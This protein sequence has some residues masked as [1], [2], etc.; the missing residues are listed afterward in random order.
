MLIFA[1]ILGAMADPN[2]W[3][4]S[5]INPD[6][7]LNIIKYTLYMRYF[8]NSGANATRELPLLV[9]DRNYLGDKKLRNFLPHIFRDGK[10]DLTLLNPVYFDNLREMI[11]IANRHNMTF[12]FSIF[13]RCHSLNMPDSPWNLN[14]QGKKGYYQWDEFTRKYVNR[15]LLTAREA[16][17][18]LMLE[19]IPF[20][21][22][23][24]LE[25]EPRDRNFV[26][27][28]IQ[29][30]KLILAAHFQ[31][32][33]IEDG[34]P[35]LLHKGG[36]PVIEKL[37]GKLI[38]NPLFDALKRA[39][40][41]IGFY[42]GVG[43]KD[44]SRYFST[45]HQIN[46]SIILEMITA[47]KHTRRFSL[48]CDGEKPKPNADQWC[49]RLELLFEAAK[50]R[51]RRERLL[52]TWKIEHVYRG[53]PDGESHFGDARD[54][55]KGISK[56]Y[57]HVFNRYPENYGKFPEVISEPP[58]EPLPIIEQIQQLNN[59]IDAVEQQLETNT[60]HIHNLKKLIMGRQTA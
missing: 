25:N 32:S 28:S 3:E 31:R 46:K 26:N 7:T 4:F 37:N 36:R 57:H 38:R 56:A 48:S 11:K 30:L 20:R 15:V 23:F 54:G 29:T 2:Q 59:R 41:K 6:G 49:E 34:V 12:Q 52:E 5:C 55:V 42:P 45:I 19:G 35:Y 47:L 40:T 27:T 13:D 21:I 58:P 18:Q 43:N 14:H 33:Q 1:S 16:E 22:L 24:E 44:K 51:P 10:Y 9:T 8:A 39:K 17:A 60:L 53:T 50:G